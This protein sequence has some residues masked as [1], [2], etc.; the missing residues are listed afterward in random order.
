MNCRV[1]NGNGVPER[2]FGP[3]A[4]QKLRGVRLDWT[5]DTCVPEPGAE[6]RRLTPDYI[7]SKPTRFIEGSACQCRFAF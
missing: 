2:G 3:S 7:G 6:L 4:P 1:L 5:K